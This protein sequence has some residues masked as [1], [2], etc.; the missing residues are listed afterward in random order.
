MQCKWYPVCPIKRF[1]EE[2]RINKHWVETYC[3]GDNTRCVRYRKEEAGEYHP[4]WML[5]DGTLDESL[6]HNHH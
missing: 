3:L 4:D 6:A 2:G 5:P 1:V